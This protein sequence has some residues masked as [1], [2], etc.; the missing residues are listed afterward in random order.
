M[1]SHG[2]LI[3]LS[4]GFFIISLAVLI[5][6]GVLVYF[7]MELKRTA[8]AFQETLKNID[9][10]VKNIEENM[11]PVLEDAGQT[12]KSIRS[13]SEDVEAVTGNVRNLSVAM[14][15]IAIN[16][17]AIS[18]MIN[19]LRGSVSLRTAGLKVGVKTALTVLAKELAKNR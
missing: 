11:K 10:S 13:V 18:S 17:K 7:L 3:F 14:Y 4:L 6:A 19:D 1:D 16:L 12:L 2:W 9:N 15:D 5:T 8:A